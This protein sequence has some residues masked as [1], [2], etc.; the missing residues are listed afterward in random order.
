[1]QQ[2]MQEAEANTSGMGPNDA[3]GAIEQ[4]TPAVPD[5][6]ADAPAPAK[7]RTLAPAPP[8]DA[9]VDEVAGATPGG[10]ELTSVVREPVEPLASNSGLS[11]VVPWA[12]G[13]IVAG[14]ALIAW[15]LHSRASAARAERRVRTANAAAAVPDDALAQDMTE[16]SDRLLM[17][18]SFTS[19]NWRP[20][21]PCAATRKARN[22]I[23]TNWRIRR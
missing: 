10:A 18:K 19:A 21:A 13:A 15:A 11:A 6:P 17:A 2:P 7:P 20:A 22:C 3:G 16:L 5:A 1:M 4:Q 12:A 9:A 14:A 8:T 23:W